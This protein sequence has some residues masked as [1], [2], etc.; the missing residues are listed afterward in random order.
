MSTSGA[1]ISGCIYVDGKILPPDYVDFP[2][3]SFPAQSNHLGT[4]GQIP[5]EVHVEPDL[6]HAERWP[7]HYRAQTPL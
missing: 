3:M 1:L 5:I 6:L 4:L 2:Q 7:A